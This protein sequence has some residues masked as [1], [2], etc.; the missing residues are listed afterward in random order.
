MEELQSKLTSKYIPD[1]TL[2]TVHNVH[3]STSAVH[4]LHYITSVR[5]IVSSFEASIDE[6]SNTLNIELV[7]KVFPFPNYMRSKLPLFREMTVDPNHMDRTIWRYNDEPTMIYLRILDKISVVS[8]TERTFEDGIFMGIKCKD[9]CYKKC[10]KH[11]LIA[12]YCFK[13]K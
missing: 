2:L 9:T 12:P 10:Y 6:E 11:Q 13:T 7:A 3:L 1:K 4:N 5:C 8:D